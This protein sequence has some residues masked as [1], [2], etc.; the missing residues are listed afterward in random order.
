MDFIA[1]KWY[2]SARICRFYLIIFRKLELWQPFKKK[3]ETFKCRFIDLFLL[4]SQNGKKP[5]VN[6]NTTKM[7]SSKSTVID[8]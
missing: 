1:L 4:I 2:L 5:V 6:L 3:N 8:R 7:L